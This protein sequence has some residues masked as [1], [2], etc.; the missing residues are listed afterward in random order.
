MLSSGFLAGCLEKP[1]GD[2]DTAGGNDGMP[3]GGDET[4]AMGADARLCVS[5]TTPGTNGTAPTW[6]MTTSMG[7]MR[8]TLYC[9]KAPVT[10]QNIVNLTESGYYDGIKFHR[11]IK[12]F[13]NQAGDPLT[14]DDT[15]QARW[16]TGGPGYTIVDEF[17][18]AD[19]TIS[20]AHPADCEELGLVHDVPGIL[21]MANTGQ[22][23]TGGSQFFITAAAT[24][25]LDAKHAIFGKAADEDSLAVALEINNVQTA[26]GDRP[27]VP[28]V[29]ESATITW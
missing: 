11:V 2:G 15:Q 1:E 17:Y 19:G 27:V 9:D 24:P 5:T 16:G 21:S 13:M 12:D 7:V 10:T 25:W 8:F 6:V 4:P 28:V 23:R 29:I 26:A 14:K 3:G 22:P 20:N 18:C